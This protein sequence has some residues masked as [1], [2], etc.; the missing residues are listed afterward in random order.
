MDN[1]SNVHIDTLCLTTH[2]KKCLFVLSVSKCAPNR[3][4][5]L[6]KA[7]SYPSIALMSKLEVSSDK[8]A[9]L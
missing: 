4:K 2:F 1:Y 3:S 5:E 9:E 8:R 6:V 7:L